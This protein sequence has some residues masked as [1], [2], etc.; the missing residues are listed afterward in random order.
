ML[1]KSNWYV[2][3]IA[4]ILIGAGGLFMLDRYN[5]LPLDAGQINEDCEPEIIIN[6]VEVEIEVDVEIERIA[7]FNITY[8]AELKR[9]DSETDYNFIFSLS[10]F[11]Q[12]A[13][14][15]NETILMMSEEPEIGLE[16]LALVCSYTIQIMKTVEGMSPL[17]QITVPYATDFCFAFANVELTWT[18]QSNHYQI[19]ASQNPPQVFDFS[20]EPFS[21]S[22]DFAQTEWSPMCWRLD[23]F[24]ATLANNDI[25]SV[26]IS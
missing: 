2:F 8:P 17:S 3:L 24:T 18:D 25:S 14:W 7:T 13:E 22:L 9:N 23:S 11:N 26:I 1:G 10:I 16:R 6:E 5:L 4:G 20:T 12:T 19:E 21:L 15:M